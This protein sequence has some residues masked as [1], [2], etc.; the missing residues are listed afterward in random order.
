LIS[1]KSKEFVPKSTTNWPKSENI[2]LF[3]KIKNLKIF[4]I[5][6]L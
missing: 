5:Q 4:G 3:L 1:E 6:V 2:G